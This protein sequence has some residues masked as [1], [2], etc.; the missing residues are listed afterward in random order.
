MAPL[1]IP[2]AHGLQ[3]GPRKLGGRVNAIAFGVDLLRPGQPVIYVGTD[4]GGVWIGKDFAKS[5]PH[6]LPLTDHLPFPPEKKINVGF[7]RSIA[8][9]PNNPLTIYAAT[10]GGLLKAVDG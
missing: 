5:P 9:D 1:F 10:D 4:G 6:W 7:V 3:A 2:V 8:V